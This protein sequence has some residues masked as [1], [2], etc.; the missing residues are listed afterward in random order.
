M[1]LISLFKINIRI[2]GHLNINRNF[3]INKTIDDDIFK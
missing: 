3:T 1:I 2:L